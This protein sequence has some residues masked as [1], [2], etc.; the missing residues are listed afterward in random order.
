VPRQAVFVRD[1]ES[2]V[3]VRDGGRFVAHPVKVVG[4][5]ESRVAITGIAEG[6]ETALLDP[7]ATPQEKS[8]A[9]GAVLD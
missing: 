9:G 6:T 3:Y 4:R 7:T 8:A 5:T 1:G 2:V